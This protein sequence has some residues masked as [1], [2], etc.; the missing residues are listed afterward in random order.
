MCD[1]QGLLQLCSAICLVWTFGVSMNAYA[2]STF[3]WKEEVLLHRRQEDHRGKIRYLR[4][5]HEP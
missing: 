4:L 1:R 5:Q 2:T 3:T